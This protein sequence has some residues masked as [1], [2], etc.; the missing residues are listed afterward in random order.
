MVQGEPHTREGALSQGLR[1]CHPK[2]PNSTE[3]STVHVGTHKQTRIFLSVTA[4]HGA[5]VPL[6][7][8]CILL[9]QDWL[10][11]VELQVRGQPAFWSPA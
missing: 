1:N 6:L 11:Q 5:M 2:V 8:L 10:L 4:A 7:A 9:P 3:C